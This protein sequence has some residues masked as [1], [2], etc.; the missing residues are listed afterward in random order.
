MRKTVS[1]AL[2]LESVE[3]VSAELTISPWLDGLEIKGRLEARVTRLCG[4]TLDPFDVIVD[5]LINLKAVPIGS[6]NLPAPPDTEVEI[7]LEDED[8]PEAYGLEGV[9]LWAVLVE[10]LALSLD[11]FPR[12]PGAIFEAPYA[13]TEDSP[14]R[15]LADLTKARGPKD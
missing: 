2:E 14:F 11:P 7:N 4:L 6:P 1:Q 15:I 12:K 5:E 8:P 3:Q 9:D 13:I 10:T